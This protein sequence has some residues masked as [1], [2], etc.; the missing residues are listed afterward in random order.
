MSLPEQ[1][2]ATI[3]WDER[4]NPPSPKLTLMGDGYAGDKV[5]ICTIILPCYMG[6][7]SDVKVITELRYLNGRRWAH[8]TGARGDQE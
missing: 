8:I 5:T 2:F 7:W 4:Y 3:E 6:D 1:I